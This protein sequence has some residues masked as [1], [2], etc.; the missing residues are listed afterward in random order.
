[1]KEPSTADVR[2]WARNRGVPVGDRGRLSPDLVAAY[3]AEKGG[4]S[5]SRPPAPR[6]G[7]GPRRGTARAE[8]AGV[9][10]APTLNVPAR[11]VHAKTPWDWPR[12]ERSGTA[13]RRRG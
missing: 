5:A 10:D 4:A 8:D 12:L 11:T 2:A 13:P 1:M 7:G 6:R 9:P 3:V